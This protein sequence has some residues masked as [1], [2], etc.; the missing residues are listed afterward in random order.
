MDIKVDNRC[1]FIFDLDDTLYPEI[2]FLKSGYNSIVR[3]LEPIIKDNILDEMLSR[4][5]SKDNVFNW[6]L[7]KY[8]D[9]GI[10]KEKLLAIYRDH[11]PNIKLEKETYH[12]LNEL[13]VNNIPMGIITDG[14]SRTQRNKLEALGIINYFDDIIISE[15]FGSEKPNPKN[16]TFFEEKYPNHRFYF[17][18]DNT[19][20][21]FIVP[22][23]LNWVTFCLSDKGEN[24]HEQDINKFKGHVIR[25]FDDINLLF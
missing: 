2:E 6:I 3:Y 11:Y 19:S 13:K 23:K 20:K 9:K 18:G 1:Y 17:F 4:Y 21:D 22:I 12:F 25:H 15:E 8:G 24:I 16:F 14:R 7:S 10:T 5:F